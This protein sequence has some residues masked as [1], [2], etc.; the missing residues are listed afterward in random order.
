[1]DYSYYFQRCSSIPPRRDTGLAPW[2]TATTLGLLRR[3]VAVGQS[4]DVSLS[5]VAIALQRPFLIALERSE[6]VMAEV[7][8]GFA[9]WLLERSQRRKQR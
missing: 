9:G 7:I 8:Q 5:G 1:M 6:R 3:Y 2:S 4:S